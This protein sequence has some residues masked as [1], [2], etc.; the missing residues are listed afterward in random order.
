MRNKKPD[1][2]HQD[3][4]V[5]LTP[6]SARRRIVTGGVAAGAASM[7]MVPGQWARPVVQAVVLPAHAQMSSPTCT[8]LVLDGCQVECGLGNLSMG[9][10]YTFTLEDG[11]IAIASAEDTTETPTA[12]DQ[13]TILCSRVEV[14]S[15]ALLL[16]GEVH[17][18]TN[19][20]SGSL[21]CG[22]PTTGTTDVDLSITVESVP[23]TATGT[24]TSS[25]DDIVVSNITVA[26][27]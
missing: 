11:C 3:P 26:P 22:S 16:A 6:V 10:R 17:D 9:T 12:A 18:F 24:I 15:V 23:F 1:P 4:S 2:H 8:A 14:D 13:L 5:S 27:A 25:E 19:S 21:N 20:E 7:L